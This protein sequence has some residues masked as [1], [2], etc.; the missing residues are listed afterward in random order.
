MA[1]TIFI[2]FYLF[3]IPTYS[4]N[5]IH[6]T[7]MMNKFQNKFQNFR[8]PVTNSKNILSLPGALAGRVLLWIEFFF[9]QKQKM[10]RMNNYTTHSTV[11][12]E[13]ENRQAKS[14]IAKAQ[15]A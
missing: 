5:L 4:E 7:L 15:Q 11:L 12:N 6:L 13:F 2:M 9:I 10:K 14:K 8:G 3:S 1:H